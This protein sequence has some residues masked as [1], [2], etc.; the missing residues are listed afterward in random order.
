MSGND[1]NHHPLL[2][3][4]IPDTK[5]L[6]AIKRMR[7]PSK[8]E[9]NK[10]NDK[11]WYI[12]WNHDV[13]FELWPTYKRKRVRIK[14]YDFINTLT[15]DERAAFAEERRLIWEYLLTRL[16]YNPFEEELNLLKGI[17]DEAI[18]VEKQIVSAEQ[19][20]DEFP[21][22]KTPISEA[23]DRWLE[24]KVSGTKNRGSK[25]NWTSVNTWL[26]KY[27]RE[28]NLLDTPASKIT[29]KHLIVALDTVKLERKW[30]GKT[31]NNNKAYLVMIFKWLTTMEYI[32]INPIEGK[33]KKQKE[34]ISINTW[35]DRDLAKLVKSTLLQNKKALPVYR[36]SQFTYL[37]C[38]RSQQE[39]LKLRV[40]DIDRRLKR[41]RFT[42][43]LSKNDKEAFRDYPE[44]F[45]TVLDEIDFNNL[46]KHYLLFGKG[47]YPAEV[48][49]GKN[50]LS[51]LFKPIK[52]QLGL[53]NDYTIYGWKH[54]RVVHEMMKGADPY[55]IQHLCR[56]SDLKETI[57]YMRDFDLSLKN[58]YTAEDLS[59]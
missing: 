10:S 25:S 20:I 49:G 46:P 53:S 12:S 39:L 58:V 32:P 57:K 15:G 1:L 40:R 51:N 26:L 11:S 52:D 14:K 34:H 33:I 56:H 43:D 22:Y 18:K 16:N 31:F 24:Y 3:G 8:P 54:T 50:T 19:K 38:I 13:P 36:A 5:I 9:I 48:S 4:H 29:A 7:P 21:L 23:L 42:S 35:Y 41:V 55:S 47:G 44:E 6:L 45:E 2:D 28:N 37:L 27:L 17:Q 30:E 59:F